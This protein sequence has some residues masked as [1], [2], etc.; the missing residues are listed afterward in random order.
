MKKIIVGLFLICGFSVTA[1]KNQ[2]ITGDFNW[3]SN[4]T[5]FK[6]KTTEYAA[7]SRIINGEISENTTLKK[8]T[9]SLVGSVYVVNGAVLTLEPGVVIRADSDSNAT[10]IITKGCKLMAVGTETDP[11][12]FTSA[13][14]SF[15]RKSGDWGGVILYGDAPVN[16]WGGQVAS[17]YD[18]NPK[19]NLFGGTNENGS[20]GVLKYVRIEFAGKKLNEKTM[21]NGL[22]LGAVGKGTKV[23]YV[24]ISLAKDD[25]I[26]AVGGVFDMSNIISFQNADDDFDFSMGAQ[27]TMSNSIAIRNPY[28]SDNTR[29]RVFE[30][31]S[32]D[33]LENFDPTKKKTYIKLNNVTMVSNEDNA[34]GLVKE[35]ISL[36][37]DSFLE[38]DRC[39]VSGFAS[40]VAFDDKYLEG[41]NYRLLKMKNSLFDSCQ[42]IIT[43]EALIR[44]EEP[45]DWFTSND[46]MNFVSRV[47]LLELFKSNDVKKKPDFRLK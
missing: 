14:S 38:L 18:P 4:W 43:N 42:E 26:E 11:I 8:G 3:F 28:I 31:D 15:D 34:M 10:L 6:P 20:S 33:K 45:S 46:K 39:V 9:Y 7:P 5:N 25:G 23:E 17:I 29:S 13:K 19:Y 30:I 40:V 35:A 36:K 16:R 32:Y 2:G 1:Q 22:T 41:Q 21:L 44:S 24:Q 12:V 27:C 47:G 37:Y